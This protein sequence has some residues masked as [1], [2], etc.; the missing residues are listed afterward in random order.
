M[1]WRGYAASGCERYENG[2]EAYRREFVGDYLREYYTCTG[3]GAKWEVE[4][5]ADPEDVVNPQTYRPIKNHAGGYC[6]YCGTD[7][8]NYTK[9][10]DETITSRG[11]KVKVEMDCL[12][13]GGWWYGMHPLEPPKKLTC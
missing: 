12:R 5:Y 3:C 1:G 13:C 10:Y 4:R 6:P 9:R 11:D 2:I 7:E 8:R